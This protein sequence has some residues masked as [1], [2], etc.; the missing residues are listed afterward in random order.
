M[1]AL[2][3]EQKAI[4]SQIIKTVF[5]ATYD[6]SQIVGVKV[7]ETTVEIITTVGG[8]W[9]LGR[10]YFKQ[11]VIQFKRQIQV[12]Q[13]SDRQEAANANYVMAL[14]TSL[15]KSETRSIQ[16]QRFSQVALAVPYGFEIDSVKPDCYRVWIGVSLLGT[17]RY[18]SKGW[19]AY[20]GGSSKLR[21]STPNA[22]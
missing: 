10:D 21:H 5:G 9:S 16:Q 22:A 18:T 1:I 4:A 13:P 12:V 7:Y 19:L 11:L 2:T 3:T 14:E 6:A 17:M 8:I 20:P 15:E